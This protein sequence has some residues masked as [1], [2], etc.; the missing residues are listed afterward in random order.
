MLVLEAPDHSLKV[1][2]VTEWLLQKK[3]TEELKSY[4]YMQLRPT[5]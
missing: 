3:T 2:A 1:E 5:R 4:R